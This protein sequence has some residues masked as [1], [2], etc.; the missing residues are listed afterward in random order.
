MRSLSKR[1]PANLTC[2]LSIQQTL[3]K[4]PSFQR[5]AC[6]GPLA[7]M[8]PISALLSFISCSASPTRGKWLLAQ[9]HIPIA[10]PYLCDSRVSGYLQ[11]RPVCTD[12]HSMAFPANQQEKRE[13]LSFAFFLY[14]H[15][16]RQIAESVST[17]LQG[18]DILGKGQKNRLLL[19]TG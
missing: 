9:P 17:H 6:I 10:L 5:N 14:F 18:S 7:W 12:N 4:P 11:V 13:V 3:Q 2:T 1:S 8:G 15:T 16:W 19:P